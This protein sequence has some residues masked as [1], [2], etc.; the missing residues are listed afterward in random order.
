VFAQ[1]DADADAD[2]GALKAELRSLVEELN[3]LSLRNDELMAER[4]QDAQGMNDMESRVEEY[5]R[6]YDAV[7]IELRNLKGELGWSISSD[8]LSVLATAPLRVFE[9]TTCATHSHF[10]HVRLEASVG[11]PFACLARRQHCRRQRI[12]LPDLCRWSALRC[13]LFCALGCFACDESHR[14]GHHRDWRG[15]QGV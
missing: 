14:R 4:E 1:G 2:V 6:K 12:C 8:S 15:R 3:A 7:R 9:L 13:A 5:K 11:R 10:H